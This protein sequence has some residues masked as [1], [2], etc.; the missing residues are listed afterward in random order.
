[1]KVKNGLALSLED[2]RDENKRGL[3]KESRQGR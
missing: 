1:M 3:W 2:K